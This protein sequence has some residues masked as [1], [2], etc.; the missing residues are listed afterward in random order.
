MTPGYRTLLSL[1]FLLEAIAFLLFLC[2]DS[3][4]ASSAST[5]VKYCALALCVAMCLPPCA[6]GRDGV[7]TAAA[8]ALSL[9]ADC[10]L[11]ILNRGYL[12][13]VALFLAVHLLH[14]VRIRAVGGW[15]GWF[16]LLLRA[17]LPV[18]LL[19][20][21]WQSGAW[22]PLYAA[23]CCYAPQLVCNVLESLTL[24]HRQ[25]LWPLLTGGLL[26]F[27]CCDLCVGLANLS[28]GQHAALLCTVSWIFYLPAQVLLTL[29]AY[30]SLFYRRKEDPA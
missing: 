12:L 20:C 9:L 22:S 16:S 2:L 19:V 28:A 25:R 30:S 14:F 15:P 29:S 24:R 5:V 6:A 21:L 8:L 1:F 13:G 10:F 3:I 11:L 17:G 27:L 18:A 23:V 4:H 7:L 26:L